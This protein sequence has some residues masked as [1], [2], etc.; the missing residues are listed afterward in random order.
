[1][2][3]L[4]ER[5]PGAGESTIIRWL[6]ALLTCYC[7]LPP[8]SLVCTGRMFM[9]LQSTLSILILFRLDP[10]TGTICVQGSQIVPFQHPRSL[11]PFLACEREVLLSL[12]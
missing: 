7:P 2:D 4:L 8:G 11:E 1:M 3:V 10:R 12:A 9:Q 5:S 6:T